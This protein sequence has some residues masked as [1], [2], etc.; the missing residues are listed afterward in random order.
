MDVEFAA[1]KAGT[2]NN[3]FNPERWLVRYQLMEILARCG[4]AKYYRTKNVGSQ[5]EGIEKI[6]TE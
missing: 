4:I 6:F 2:K 3:I 5:S 1:T